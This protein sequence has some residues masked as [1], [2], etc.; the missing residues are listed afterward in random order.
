MTLIKPE[1]SK[2]NQGFNGHTLEWRGTKLNDISKKK[3]I[4]I[5]AHL[6]AANLALQE[7]LKQVKHIQGIIETPYS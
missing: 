5:I 4:D 7:E 3:L 2:S 1:E 6:F